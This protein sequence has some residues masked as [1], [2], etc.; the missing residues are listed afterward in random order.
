MSHD[1]LTHFATF[2]ILTAQFYFL[3]NLARP[4][5]LTVAA[6]T[7]G[8]SIGLEYLQNWVN[9]ARKFDPVDILYNISGSALAVVLCLYFTRDRS[10]YGLVNSQDLETV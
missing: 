2:L 9:P 8:A 6:M 4:W 1:K 10:G 3:W 7:V 5:K